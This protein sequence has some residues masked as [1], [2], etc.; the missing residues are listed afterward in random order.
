MN[1]KYYRPPHRVRTVFLI[2]LLFGICITASGC[3]S[4]LADQV[5]QQ[6]KRLFPSIID[7]TET[8]FQPIPPTLTPSPSPSPTPEPVRELIVWY[9]PAIPARL[10]DQIQLPPDIRTSQTKEGSNLQ[11]GAIQGNLREQVTWLYVIAAPYPTLAD[12]ISLDEITRA[13]RG[14]SDDSF[15]G[16]LL[17]S[18]QTR[19]AFA[20]RWGPNSNARVETVPADNLADRAWT[21]HSNWAILPLE[22]LTPQ[23]KALRVDSMSLFDH[24]IDIEAYPLS[25]WFGIS[26][27][28]DAIQ[29]LS[30]K[31]D[32][33]ADLL[34]ASNFDL[35]RMTILTMSGVTALARATGYKMDTLGTTYPGQDVR[36]WFL[37]ADLAHISNEVSFNKDC[38]KANFYSTST[39]FCSRPEYIEL[40]DYLGIDIVE[41]SGNHNNDWGRAAFSYSLDLYHERNLSYFAGGANLE[42]ARQPLLVE[43]NGNRLAF[44]GCNPVGP[45]AAWATDEQP[46]AAPCKD[47]EWILAE[48]G[49][50]RDEGY[51]PIVTFQYYEIYSHNPSDHQVNNF[52]AAVDAGAVIVSGSQAHFPQNM[53]FYNE[54]FIHY[55]LGN[56]FFDQMDNPV[57]GTRQEFVDRHIFYDGK[58]IQ[59]ELLTALL[60]DYARPRKMNEDE[61]REFLSDIFQSAGW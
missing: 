10:F 42:E 26:G 31:I 30:Q 24:G 11:I 56:L 15:Q 25:I 44:I 59:A 8:P 32:D 61:R 18:E 19:A 47:Y 40:L 9:D 12:E 58:H 41:L 16:T 29:L 49:R 7:P 21:D 17:M 36:D 13:W 6:T 37:N 2:L 1:H 5:S 22:D 52:R 46:G 34:P 50:L 35:N 48:I 43:H 3:S 33:E 39:L 57:T 55:G 14:E 53:E 27:E 45:T 23:W 54:A 4:A 51:L 38:P 20:A 60:E 28:P